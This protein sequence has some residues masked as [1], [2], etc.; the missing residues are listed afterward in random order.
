[1]YPTEEQGLMALRKKP[2]LEPVKDGWDGPYLYKEPPKDP[3]GNEY[4]YMLLN[5]GENAY[6]IRS[7]GSDGKEGGEGKAED[8]CSWKEE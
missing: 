5:D 4:E 8:I 3:W 7:F 2:V 6:G 1:M